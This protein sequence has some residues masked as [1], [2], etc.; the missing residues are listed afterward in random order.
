MSQNH[1]IELANTLK[2]RPIVCDYAGGRF[3]LTAE[4]LTF[5]GI[6]K[7]GTPLPP[8][9]ICPPLY[10]V[11]KTRDAQSGEWGRLL[12][13]QDDDGVTHQWAMPLA[14]L[15]GDASDVRRELARLGLSISPN[16]TARDL[17]ASYLQVFPVDARARCVDKLGWHGDVFVTASQCIGNSTEK[18]VFQNTNAIEPAVSVKGSV[19]EWRDSIGRLASGNSR[20]VFAISVALAPV[21]A[22][23]VGE[24]SGGFHFRGA[25]SSGKSTALSLAASVWGNPQSYCRLWRSTTNGLEGLAAL[26]NDGLLILDELSQMDPRE[27]GEAAYLLAN[28]QG[29]TRASRT[30]TVRQSSRW[31]LF[32]LS[33][34]EESLT[35]LMAKSGQRINAGQEIRLADIEADAGCQ[36]GIFETI[37]DQL[38]PASMALSLK[39]YSSRYHGAIGLAWLNQVVAN[40]KT[41]SRYITDTIQTFIDSVIQPDA[42][43]QI[44]RVARRF[45]LVAAAGELASQFGLTGWQ[46]GESFHAAKTCFM[47]WQDTF[48]VDG[49]HEDRAIMAQ[50]R[51]FF[52]SHGASRFDSANSPNN[53]KIL[54]RAGFYH[55]DGEGFRIYMVLTEAYKNELC[56]GFDQRTVTRV[57]LQADWLKPAPDGKASHKPRIKGVGTPRLYVFTGKIWGGE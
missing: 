2:Q 40:R 5:I 9:W 19:E 10:V 8:R 28:G 33:A 52:E 50:V 15:Q 48:G 16:R 39:K 1:V 43:G 27:A 35:A 32:F 11:A 45:A 12:E 3:R 26:H 36:M 29:K 41:I 38:S 17:L 37:H 30:G 55:T 24:D 42:T 6:D 4:G 44:I 54:N 46:K 23:I 13:W 18:I 51:A 31:S 25:S 53:D 20:L 14:L 34:G 56:K 49:H 22:K 47:A 57:L 7:D 21:L